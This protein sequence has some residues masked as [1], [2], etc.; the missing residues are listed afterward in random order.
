MTVIVDYDMGNVGSIKNMLKRLGYDATITSDIET[1]KHAQKIILPGVGAFDM[2]MENLKNRGLIDVLNHKARIEKTPILGICLGMQLMT[3]R[4]DEGTLS[5][6]GW[7]EAETL[8]FEIKD[9]KIPHMG[10]N[11]IQIEQESPLFPNTGEYNRFY[12]V[13]SYYVKCLDPSNIATTTEYGDRF[14]SSFV[15]E[16]IYGVQF[17]PEKSHSYGFRLLKHFMEIK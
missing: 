3:L 13:H 17:H 5:G 7:L 9:K 12:F 1:I 15:K 10:W 6:L 14:V 4:S 8:K 16:N 11:E 2:G